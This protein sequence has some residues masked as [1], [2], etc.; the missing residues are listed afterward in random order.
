MCYSRLVN[1]VKKSD[2]ALKRKTCTV[3]EKP[4]SFYPLFVWAVDTVTNSFVQI[5][6]VHT[7]Y[8]DSLHR[9]ETKGSKE[10]DIL[11]I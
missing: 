3:A 6:G 10:F 2:A 5:T 11:D 4:R 9:R 8:V 1:T 7:L